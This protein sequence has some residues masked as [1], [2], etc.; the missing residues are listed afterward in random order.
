LTIIVVSGSISGLID[1]SGLIG[2]SGPVPSNIG[3]VE[4]SINSN[5]LGL[6]RPSGGSSA[7]GSESCTGSS[8]SIEPGVSVFSGVIRAGFL[9]FST[10]ELVPD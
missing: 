3:K 7:G 6:A 8:S 2:T 5:E 10:L 1:V 9:G 4:C